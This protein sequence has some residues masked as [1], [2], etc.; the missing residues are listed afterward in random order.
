VRDLFEDTMRAILADQLSAEQVISAEGGEFPV[1]LWASLEEN[2]VP[3]ALVAED[4]G[5]A[6]GTLSDVC[7]LVIACGEHCAPLPIIETMLA[8]YLLAKHGRAPLTGVV[9]FSA[10]DGLLI[11]KGLVSGAL[12][13]VPWGRNCDYVLAAVGAELLVLSAAAARDCQHISNT[14]GEPRD[15]LNFKEAKTL[16]S[17]PMAAGESNKVLLLCGALVRSAQITGAIMRVL[18]MAADYA[19]ERVQFG[20]PIARFQAVQHQMALLA[21]QASMAKASCEVAFALSEQSFHEDSIAA[22]KICSSDAAGVAAGVSHGVHGAIGFTHEYPLHIATRRLWSW[23]S[24]F[25]SSSY[26]SCLLGE[27]VC[28]AGADNFWPRLV[29]GSF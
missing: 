11:N 21:E 8:N 28:V 22:A 18:M 9:S 16:I 13:N 29:A 2:G 14:A 3:L 7:G 17:I 24:E 10:S 20:K 15:T 25:G 26:W 23:R 4:A 12:T 27:R 1:Q 5:G 6:G 19:N